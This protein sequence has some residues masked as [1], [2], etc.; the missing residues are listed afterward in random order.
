MSKPGCS[1]AKMNSGG[2]APKAVRRLDEKLAEAQWP[3]AE[4]MD[5][6]V[7][8]PRDCLVAAMGFEERALAVLERACE[9]SQNFHLALV[10]YL[11]R[12]TENREEEFRALV[13]ARGLSAQ[14]FQ[15]D[16][17]RPAGMGR[18][19]AEH[20][21]AFDRVVIDVSGMSR[22]LIVQIIVAMEE[23]GKV[24]EVFYSEAAIY[25]PTQEQ[26]RN[27]V[28]DAHRPAFISSGI[29]EVVSSP[30]LSSVA[31]LGSPIRLVS[32]LSFDCNQLRNL[33]QEIQPT[34]NDV[35]CGV[36]PRADMLWRRDAL[37]EMNEATVGMLRRAESH[38]ACTFD[39]RVSLKLILRV[40]GNH[41][42]FDRLVIAPTGS[43]MQALA[44][45]IIRSLLKDV[46]IV[47][48]T[49][50]RFLDPR[51]YTV[52]VRRIVRVPVACWEA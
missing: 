48:P 39:Y 11:P 26:Y 15:Y 43:K 4:I 46:Q 24:C 7:I 35:V 12:V 49:P 13:R 30:E 36:P 31:M 44:V 23:K 41:S 19:L 21:S 52:G 47:Y 18:I 5:D 2:D 17:R 34:H 28:S 32:F 20:A 22:L 27:A 16:R 38:E 8:G 40:Y 50:R 14:W 37:V 10:S 9:A 42:V 45:G 6:I 51:H 29:I 25:P 3:E 33:V 1:T